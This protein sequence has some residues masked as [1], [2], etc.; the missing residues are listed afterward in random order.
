[1]D[2]QMLRFPSSLSDEYHR[3][4]N[5]ARD[6]AWTWAMSFGA[7][8]N[9]ASPTRAQV[10]MTANYGS[11]TAQA[12]RRDAPPACGKWRSRIQSSERSLIQHSC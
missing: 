9:I 11:G 3:K 1:M 5:T 2:N 7:F 10:F 12:M 6:Y 4:T 8:A